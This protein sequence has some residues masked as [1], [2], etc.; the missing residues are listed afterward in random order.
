MTSEAVHSLSQVSSAQ[1]CVVISQ[2]MYFPWVGILEQ[3]RLCNTFVHYEDV[4][5]T[6]GS[7][8]N[9]VQIKT[10]SGMRWLTVPLKGHKLG[11]LI[12]EVEIDYRS[13]W[14]R[15]HNETLKHAYA[16]SSYKSEMLDLVGEV[17]SHQHETLAELSKAS[18]MSLV[19]YF[20]LEHG[21]TFTASPDLNVLGSSTQRVIDICTR[22]KANCYLTGHG[23]RN[24]LEHE[25]FESEGV[26]VAYVDYGLSHYKQ[27]HGPFTPYVTALDLIANCG[28]EG[29]QHINGKPTPWREFI[30]LKNE[31]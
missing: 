5:F 30:A 6:R 12:N 26:D 19:R 15:N 1:K 27:L 16:K 2:P 23:A 9:R 17:F 3:I 18:M 24:Y 28:K 29:L 4:Q 8:S 13:D 21:R 7:F 14:R 31:A 22:T 11:Q 20:G 25:A 10:E